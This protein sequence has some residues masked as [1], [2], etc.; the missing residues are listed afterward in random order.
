MS[1]IQDTAP[2]VDHTR[3]HDL[4][5]QGH[6][7]AR[8]RALRIL[9]EDHTLPTLTWTIGDVTRQLSGCV[10]GTDYAKYCAVAAWALFLGVEVTAKAEP[11]RVNL[12]VF[13]RAYGVPVMVFA[14]CKP[15]DQR[16]IPSAGKA[17]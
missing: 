13:G 14:D 12:T 2:A 15:A 9:L 10:Y 7:A 4:T 1:Q 11:E 6:Q 16:T 3:D 5:V 8:A 17:A